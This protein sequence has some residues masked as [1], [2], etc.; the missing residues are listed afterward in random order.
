M[1]FNKWIK[2]IGTLQSIAFQLGGRI[3]VVLLL[4][5]VTLS[6]VTGIDVFIAVLIVGILATIYTVP[7]AAITSRITAVKWPYLL[8]VVILIG[9]GFRGIDIHFML[10]NTIAVLSCVTIG[11]AVSLLTNKSQNNLEGLTIYNP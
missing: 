7:G 8:K 9:G 5:A 2:K 4:P 6:A 3:S 10:Y 11:Y 1:R